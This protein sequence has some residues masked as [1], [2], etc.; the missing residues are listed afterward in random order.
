MFT[1]IYIS[2]RYQG[3]FENATLD[4]KEWGFGF[5]R[6]DKN[7]LVRNAVV[8]DVGLSESR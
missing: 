1:A 2:Y 6:S 5:V 8:K 7:K 3:S 4:H